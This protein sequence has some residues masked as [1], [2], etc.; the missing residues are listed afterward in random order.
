MLTKAFV[1]VLDTDG[2]PDISDVMAAAGV[3]AKNREQQL[4]TR[5]GTYPNLAL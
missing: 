5:W 4:L 3:D 1:F 2:D